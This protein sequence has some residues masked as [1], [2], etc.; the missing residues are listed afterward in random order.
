MFVTTSYDVRR[1][2]K[3]TMSVEVTLNTRGLDALLAHWDD[4][5]EHIVESV[6]YNVLSD[7]QGRAPVKTGYLRNSGR[8][9]PAED[10]FSRYVHFA[11]NYALY[12]HEGTRFMTGRPF[13]RQAIEHQ[14]GSFQDAFSVLGK[15]ATL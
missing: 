2:V 14:R 1:V 4:A 10:R 13:L 8:V 12:V 5:I 11:A 3:A 6:A 15:L 7:A 9:E